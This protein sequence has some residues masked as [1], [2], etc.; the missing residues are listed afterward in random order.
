M[1][2][3]RNKGMIIIG[4]LLAFGVFYLS[5]AAA[6]DGQTVERLERL[7]KEQQQQLESMQRQLNELKQTAADALSSRSSSRNH[8]SVAA[9]ARRAKR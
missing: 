4:L 9:M 7:I 3:K 8:D 6:Q 2:V 5:P 1:S